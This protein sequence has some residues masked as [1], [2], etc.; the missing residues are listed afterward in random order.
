MLWRDF[1]DVEVA[2]NHHQFIHLK[3]SAHNV[4][5]AWVTA[6]YASPHSS[7]RHEL[8]HQLNYIARSMH[9]PWLVG[10]DFNSILYAE[11]KCGGS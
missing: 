8:L 5:Q 9:D 7:R 4:T 11:E 10:G 2:L 3:I 6:V 1:F